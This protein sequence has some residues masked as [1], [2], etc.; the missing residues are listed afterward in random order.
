MDKNDFTGLSVIY[1]YAKLRSEGVELGTIPV[2]EDKNVT[3]HSYKGR[4][5]E[6]Y[7]CKYTDKLLDIDFLAKENE[8]DRLDIYCLYIQLNEYE[9][10]LKLNVEMKKIGIVC[11]FCEYAWYVDGKINLTAIPACPI[12]DRRRYRFMK[13]V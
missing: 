4:I 8:S 10:S 1:R 2:R 13:R 3:L 7:R 5:V 9:N 12:C 6:E 11:V